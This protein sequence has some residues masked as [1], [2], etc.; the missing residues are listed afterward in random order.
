VS[1]GAQILTTGLYLEPSTF[2][3]RACALC[4]TAHREQRLLPAEV[5]HRAVEVMLADGE[6]LGLFWC[7]LGEVFEDARF[8][9]LLSDLD[10]RW[11]GR[12]LH[13]VQTNGL[14]PGAALPDPGGKVA[15]VSLDLPRAFHEAHRGRDAWHPAVDFG[16]R[17]LAAGGLGLGIK[18]LLTTRTLPA[19]ARSFPGLRATLARQSGLPLAVVRART[20]LLPIVPF[21]RAQVAEIQN[22][23]FGARGGVEDPTALRAAARRLLPGC[24]AD[25]DRPRT[26]E[27][28]VTSRGLFSCCEAVIQVGEHADLW[29]LDREAL[30]AR[31]RAAAPACET[32]PL[33]EAC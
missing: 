27:L 5:V 22:A 30:L 33:R 16:A 14:V 1:R 11:P 25:L 18:C 21:P 13:V 3:P 19:V 28:S 31:V 17:H 8:P 9:G 6:T 10:A 15:L 32:C 12:L 4:Y 24:A 2:C 7:G 20:W 23:A 26:L 29:R